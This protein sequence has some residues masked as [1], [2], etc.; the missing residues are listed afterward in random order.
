MC[1]D[2]CE[3]FPGLGQ[4]RCSLRFGGYGGISIPLQRL[5]RKSNSSSGVPVW[6]VDTV[7][8][9]VMAAINMPAI[10]V[11]TCHGDAGTMQS[12]GIK[13]RPLLLPIMLKI[14]PQMTIVSTIANSCTMLHGLGSLHE[15]IMQPE[16]CRI[17]LQQ[18]RERYVENKSGR[19]SAVLSE[20]SKSSSICSLNSGS[21]CA[22]PDALPM[23][24]NVCC[25]VAHC[26]FTVLCQ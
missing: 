4:Y 23:L 25:H 26:L 6:G 19:G 11:L 9:P 21:P 8:P 13:Q 14:T 17:V 18:I 2:G 7:C 3:K 16:R 12:T 5:Q 10:P 20:H 24:C 22:E 1:L 15:L